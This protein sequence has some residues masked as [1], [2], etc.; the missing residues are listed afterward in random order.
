MTSAREMTD[1]KSLNGPR[2][3]L[4]AD[5]EHLIASG[6]AIMLSE[7]GCEV[8]GPASNGQAAIDL[9]RT[10]TPDMAL[11]DIRMPIMD[12]LTAARTIWGELR[13]PVVIL[14]AFSDPENV[15]Q[16]T[17]IGVFAYLLKPADRDALRVTL[18]IAWSRSRSSLDQTDRIV[19]LEKNL[20]QRRIVEQAKWKIVEHCS[21]TEAEAHRRLQ[22]AARNNRSPLSEVAERVIEEGYLL[23]D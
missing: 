21:I 11:L 1:A 16:C 5:D 10:A 23:K 20:A 17:N 9:A 7:L 13:I 18:S 2:R 15:D 6:L 4:I 19:Q 22:S 12:G 14:S 8:I 3:V